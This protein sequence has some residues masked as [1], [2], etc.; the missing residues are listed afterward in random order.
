MSLYDD[1]MRD[2]LNDAA[3]FRT[4]DDDYEIIDL[5]QV[6]RALLNLD[7]AIRRFNLIYNIALKVAPT[8]KDEDTLIAGRRDI[9]AVFTALSIIQKN[10]EKAVEHEEVIAQNSIN[11]MAIFGGVK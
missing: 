8:D 11:E 9:D 7:K 5:D 10:L 2:A 6:Q 1:I 4:L 3:L